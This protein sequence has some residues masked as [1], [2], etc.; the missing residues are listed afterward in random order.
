VAQTV[1]NTLDTLMN[2]VE[3]HLTFRLYVSIMYTVTK[4]KKL[5]ALLR[6]CSVNSNLV[7]RIALQQNLLELIWLSKGAIL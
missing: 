3:P 4:Y 2:H 1:A 7:C 5:I 6:L